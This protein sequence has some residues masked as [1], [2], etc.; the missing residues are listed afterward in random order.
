VY[1]CSTLVYCNYPTFC[2]APSDVFYVLCCLFLSRKTCIL[3]LVSRT[4]S[5][6]S[7]VSDICRIASRV[8]RSVL[9]ASFIIIIII[10]GSWC[11]P[12]GS[13]GY[14]WMTSIVLSPLSGPLLPSIS[15]LW[16]LCPHLYCQ[17]VHSLGLPLFVFPS[18]LACSALCEIRS[19]VILSTCPNRR[20][21]GSQNP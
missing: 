20:R 11:Q 17:S 19:T 18:N 8:T 6:D 10:F 9:A 3:T 15:V 4:K 16:I 13:D 7:L 21:T 12:F 14:K 1:N 5:E 2:Y